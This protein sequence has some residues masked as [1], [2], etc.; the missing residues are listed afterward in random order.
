MKKRN[1]W[2]IG[3]RSA[4]LRRARHRSWKVNPLICFCK[5]TPYSA[6]ILRI[7]HT[8]VYSVISFSYQYMHS[9]THIWI[10][11]LN[12]LDH[13][14]YIIIEERVVAYTVHVWLWM[15]H[16]CTVLKHQGEKKIHSFSCIF[17]FFVFRAFGD[18]TQHN[19]QTTVN[20]WRVR[21]HVFL[22]ILTEVSPTTHSRERAKIREVFH[23]LQE[24]SQHNEPH[25]I[26]AFAER[27]SLRVLFVQNV[28]KAATGRTR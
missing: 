16:T 20:V 2:C 9:V 1:S 18:G 24:C 4:R 8:Y 11:F 28:Y 7:T 6:R 15:P 22:E 21:R 3:V 25:E 17:V 23:L 13:A 14:W 12:W 5:N 26:D 19:A 27:F 10:A